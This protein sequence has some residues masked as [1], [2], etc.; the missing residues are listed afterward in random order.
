MQRYLTTY[1]KKLGIIVNFRQ[2]YL[3]PKRVLN[4]KFKVRVIYSDNSDYPR[5]KNKIR[6]KYSDNSDFS[7]CLDRFPKLLSN[8]TNSIIQSEKMS[9]KRARFLFIFLILYK[10]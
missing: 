7:D 10:K 8:S 2:K 4:S 5:S 1:K 6:V 3:K 9:H